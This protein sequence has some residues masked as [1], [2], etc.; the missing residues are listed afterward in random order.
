MT[1]GITANG[2]IFSMFID[3]GCVYR[4]TITIDDTS[5]AFFQFNEEQAVETLDSVVDDYIIMMNNI[6][7]PPI[8]IA[9][10]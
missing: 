8:I 9:E 10:N 1:E 7:E 6:I 4:Y 2:R 5:A 3:D